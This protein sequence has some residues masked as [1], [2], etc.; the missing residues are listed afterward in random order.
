MALKHYTLVPIGI[1]RDSRVAGPLSDHY[2]EALQFFRSSLSSLASPQRRVSGREIP[3]SWGRAL[4]GDQHDCAHDDEE[5]AADEFHY[6]GGEAPGEKGTQQHSQKSAGNQSQ[7][8][9]QEHGQ[10]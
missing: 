3:D 6:M 1:Y 8:G 10:P 5:N 7:R 2:Q 4:A 9:T